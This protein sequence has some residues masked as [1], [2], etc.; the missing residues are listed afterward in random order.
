MKIE[1]YKKQVAD[2]PGSRLEYIFK[3]GG[4]MTD[5]TYETD[6]LVVGSGGGGLTAALV[7]KML[8]KEAIVVEKTQYYG[9]STALSGGGIWVPGNYLMAEAEI[10]DSVENGLTYMENTVGDRTPR[11]NREAY[12]SKAKEMLEYLTCNTHVKF[13]IMDGYPD[14][15]PENPGGTAGG[16][17]LEPI[18]F[19]GK[20]LGRLYDQLRPHP[21]L[22]Y[23]VVFTL[24]DW[25]KVSMVRANPANLIKA[26]G[27]FLRSFLNIVF[28]KRHLTLGQALVGRLRFSLMEHDVPVWVNTAVKNLIVENGDVIGV[29]AEK[30]SK[31]IRIRAK[32][33]VILAAGG[34]PHNKKM[35]ETYFK[36]PASTDW[37]SA[38][39]GNTGDAI[40]MGMT[41]GASV[42]LMDDA[43]W[44]PTTLV[45]DGP[46]LF[47]VTER[48]Y[49]GAIIVNSKGQRFVNEAAPYID[50]VH[51]M[52]D[53]NSKDTMAIPSYFIMDQRFRSRYFL[54]ILPPGMTPKKYIKQE[55]MKKADSLESLAAQIDVNPRGLVDTVQR[56]NEFARAGKDQDF[57]R[58]DSIY[59]RYYADPDI[60]PN[61]CLAPITKPPY[62]A[63]KLYPGDLGTKGGLVTNEQ[64]QVLK[65]DKT[66]INGLY[67]VG[68]TSAS[69]MGHSY[70]GPGAT[71]G[72]SMTFG[73]IAAHHAAGR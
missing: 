7:A 13:Q 59:D 2:I 62:Y 5:W 56:F 38:N 65:E 49:P 17:A 61:P 10:P 28:R 69:V 47:L 71:I 39:S 42:D 1:T 57:K 36:P 32:K 15:Y 43:W 64:A 58:G 11:V 6:I 26:S 37:T 29:E 35:R 20:K 31:P 16:R 18:L 70:P 4:K 14:Y 67:A 19:E 21:Y 3:S 9:G 8:G 55:K 27:F 52:Y 54:G 68:N 45:F 23:S 50:V 24:E 22:K 46:P 41:I 60:K 72:P 34:F 53:E 44:G 51:A 73:F 63:V 30:E 48:G 33:G 25:K 66:I 12:V 40:Q